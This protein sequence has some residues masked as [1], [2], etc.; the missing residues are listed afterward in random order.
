MSGYTAPLLVSM[1]AYGDAVATYTGQETES[2]PTNSH[3]LVYSAA[4]FTFQW[5]EMVRV[6]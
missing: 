1:G 2:R 5:N 4:Q 6:P 3:P